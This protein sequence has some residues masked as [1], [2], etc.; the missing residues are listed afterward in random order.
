MWDVFYSLQTN[1]RY[2]HEQPTG[3]DKE[4]SSF[5]QI[6]FLPNMSSIDEIA[7]LFLWRSSIVQ[8]TMFIKKLFKVFS[9]TNASPNTLSCFIVNFSRP[10]VFVRLELID[11]YNQTG[12]YLIVY[13]LMCS[14]KI[15]IISFNAWSGSIVFSFLFPSLFCMKVLVTSHS[16]SYG[17][18]SHLNH[19]Y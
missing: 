16:N 2:F 8:H 13:L 12:I 3:G 11:V 6:W 18:I 14:S 10:L 17:F 5:I 7:Y 15:F 4:H 19:F 9:F 1:R